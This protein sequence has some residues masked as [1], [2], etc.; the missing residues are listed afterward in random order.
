MQIP[1][2][3]WQT[4]LL[5][6]HYAAI[7]ALEC[8]QVIGELVH[9]T[10]D[11]SSA[12]EQEWRAGNHLDRAFATYLQALAAADVDV[13]HHDRPDLQQMDVE[14]MTRDIA[15][16]YEELEIS[17]AVNELIVDSRRL[18]LDDLDD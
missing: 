14:E 11:Q 5:A 17:D 13:S 3:A 15:R 2:E 10:A 6:Y 16:L 9:G 8:G 18:R 1:E 7:S 4:I 12:L